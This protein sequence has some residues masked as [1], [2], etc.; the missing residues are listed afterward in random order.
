MYNDLSSFQGINA[1]VITRS[2]LQSRNEFPVAKSYV[3]SQKSKEHK[4]N[5]DQNEAITMYVFLM[6]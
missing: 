5:R 4:N 3:L 6:L 2:I 1:N